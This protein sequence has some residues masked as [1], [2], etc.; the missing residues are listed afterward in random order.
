MARLSAWLRAARDAGEPLPD[1]M[2]LATSSV[3]G[4]PSARMVMLRGLDHGLVFFT[5]LESD[6]G[7]ELAEN[8]RAAVVLHWLAPEH[9]QVRLVGGVEQV[10]DEEAER[11]WRARRP[12]ARRSAAAS[13]QSR[14][15]TDRAV[16]EE[17][18]SDL[19]RRFPDG[20]DLLRPG[21]W[22]GY[23]VIPSSVEFWQEAPDGLHDRFRYRRDQGS[24]AV[25]R[26]SP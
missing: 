7:L 20:V 26:L 19:T 21:R 17:A 1:A 22:S 11:Y 9:R 15:V 18:V 25:E 8:P 13:V 6:K 2:S 23:R 3:D 12:E 14:V 16:L 4:Q 10:S 5:D 24:W